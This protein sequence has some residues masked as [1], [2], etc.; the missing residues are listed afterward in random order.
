[1]HIMSVLFRKKP[2][3]TISMTQKKETNALSTAKKNNTNAVSNSDKNNTNAVRMTPKNDTSAVSISQK[4]NTSDVSISQKNDTSA[5]SISQ[6]NNMS[7]VSI[8]HKEDLKSP[9]SITLKKDTTCAVGIVPKTDTN[10]DARITPKQEMENTGSV[11]RRQVTKSDLCST[12][13]QDRNSNASV[14]R[15]EIRST[16]STQVHITNK[17]FDS[18]VDRRADSG[19]KKGLLSKILLA[20][21]KAN[22]QRLDG[23]NQPIPLDS[24]HFKENYSL[25]G[26]R[27]KMG[28]EE[29]HRSHYQTSG[30]GPPNFPSRR[31]NVYDHRV[32]VCERWKSEEEAS[33]SS[34]RYFDHSSTRTFSRWRSEDDVSYP[35]QLEED[36][37]YPSQCEDHISYPSHC[38]DDVSYPSQ[39]EDDVSY[40]S[41]R[42]DD[43][44]YPSQREDDVSYPSQREDDVSYQ[45]CKDDVS[46]S[47]QHEDDVSYPSQRKDNVSYPS[48]HEDD[49]SYP[50]QR[51]DDVSYPS[52]CEDTRNHPWTYSQ[53]QR[54]EIFTFSARGHYRS[55]KSYDD[56]NYLYRD[57]Y[58]D[59]E[60]DPEY[61]HGREYDPKY[62]R[63]Y[64]R[65][66]YPD[67]EYDPDYDPSRR[68]YSRWEDNR[69]HVHPVTK[70]T[71]YRRQ[72]NIETTPRTV[73]YRHLARVTQRKRFSAFRCHSRLVSRMSDTRKTDI[74]DKQASPCDMS[75]HLKVKLTNPSELTTIESELEMAGKRDDKDS[76]KTKS[77]QKAKRHVTVPGDQMGDGDESQTGES[78]ALVLTE[79]DPLVDEETS[80]KPEHIADLHPSTCSKSQ[81]STTEQMLEH[82]VPE[83]LEKSVGLVTAMQC[84]QVDETNKMDTSSFQSVRSALPEC[85]KSL[86]EHESLDNDHL[87]GFIIPVHVGKCPARTSEKTY[88]CTKNISKNVPLNSRNIIKLTTDSDKKMTLSV[89]RTVSDCDIQSHLQ[90]VSEHDIQFHLQSVS[91]HD[92][93]SH[94]QSISDHDIQSHLQSVS[95]HD[96]QSHLQSDSDHDIQSHLQ[97]DSDH[98]IQ[99]HLQSVSDHDI[100]SHLQSVSDHDIQ[101]HFQSDSDHDIQS[102][103]QSVSDHDIQSHL[104]S[105]SDHD[106]QSHLQSDSDHDIQFH[107][108]TENTNNSALEDLEITMCSKT[109][110]TESIPSGNLTSF[111]VFDGSEDFIPEG[112]T[113]QKSDAHKSSSED[114]SIRKG[115]ESV[116][117]TTIP[118]SA[119]V[120]SERSV[121]DAVNRYVD[122]VPKNSRPCESHQV[123]NIPLP[124][125]F[126]DVTDHHEREGSTDA[127]IK[128]DVKESQDMVSKTIESDSPQSPAADIEMD[129]QKNDDALNVDLHADGQLLLGTEKMSSVGEIPLLHTQCSDAQPSGVAFRKGKNDLQVTF[130]SRQDNIDFSEISLPQRFK[131][132]DI[133][134]QH[135]EHVPKIHTVFK[136]NDVRSSRTIIPAASQVLTKQ[137]GPLALSVSQ[138]TEIKTEGSSTTETGDQNGKVDLVFSPIRPVVTSPQ[139]GQ[140]PGSKCR[141]ESQQKVA[142][143][144]DVP[145]IPTFAVSVELVH[146][147]SVG[148][149][150]SPDKKSDKNVTKDDKSADD[151]CPVK[152]ADGPAKDTKG[153]GNKTVLLA[154]VLS[155]AR[156][157]DILISK[158]SKQIKAKENEVHNSETLPESNTSSD[159]THLCSDDKQMKE[160]KQNDSHSHEGALFSPLV[161]NSPCLGSKNTD[162]WLP[163]SYMEHNIPN[164]TFKS[165]P[166]PQ[167]SVTSEQNIPKPVQSLSTQLSTP[168]IPCVS[169]SAQSFPSQSSVQKIPCI[170]SNTVEPVAPY[171]QV[172]K[173]SSGQNIPSVSPTSTEVLTSSPKRARHSSGKASV[174]T[175]GICTSNL[176]EVPLVQL[177]TL[178]GSLCRS[179]SIS[180][181]SYNPPIHM[182]GIIPEDLPKCAT[183]KSVGLLTNQSPVSVQDINDDGE[184]ARIDETSSISSKEKT[185]TKNVVFLQNDS[186]NVLKKHI[187][188]DFSLQAST[189]YV[190]LVGDN[191]KGID[192]QKNDL[193]LER[194]QEH[195]AETWTSDGHS[196]KRRFC[197]DDNVVPV[198]QHSA[199]VTAAR[200]IMTHGRSTSSK[201]GLS[202]TRYSLDTDSTKQRQSSS[203]H[204]NT[205][206][207]TWSEMDKNGT[208][209]SFNKSQMSSFKKIFQESTRNKPVRTTYASIACP[210]SDLHVPIQTSASMAKHSSENKKSHPAAPSVFLGIT[211]YSVKPHKVKPYKS[212]HSW[213]DEKSHSSKSFVL[214]KR[215][216]LDSAWDPDA[217]E[218]LTDVAGK[219]HKVEKRQNPSVVQKRKVIIPKTLTHSECI[220]VESSA[221]SKRVSSQYEVKHSASSSQVKDS[222]EQSSELRFKSKHSAVL[223]GSKG[224]EGGLESK[225]STVHSRSSVVPPSVSSTET[226]AVHSGS[227]MSD[228]ELEL[229]HSTVHSRSSV[230][231]PSVSSTETLAVHSGSKMSD[232]ELE[233]K[234][235]TV[236]SR[237]SVVPPSV[238]STETLAV[239]SGS[240]MSDLELEPKHSI[241]YSGSKSLD[242]ELESKHFGVHS[243][244][245][246]SALK[247]ELKHCVVQ[248][249]PKTLDPLLEAKYSGILSGAKSSEVKLKPAESTKKSSETETVLKSSETQ[250]KLKH[251]PVPSSSKSGDVELKPNCSEDFTTS[252]TAAVIGSEDEKSAA[253]VFS[254]NDTSVTATTTISRTNK[255]VSSK[256]VTHFHGEDGDL[257]SIDVESDDDSVDEL[258]NETP[259]ILQSL[260][261]RCNRASPATPDCTL[262]SSQLSDD[263][264]LDLQIATSP[265]HISKPA[266]TSKSGFSLDFLL[267]EKIEKEEENRELDI[268]HAE[269]KEGIKK[270]GFAKLTFDSEDGN[271]GDLLPEYQ[272][273][274]HHF[275][276]SKSVIEDV[277]PGDQVFSA[278][279]FQQ[280][281][282]ERILP[283]SCG[284]VSSNTTIDKHLFTIEPALVCDLVN[285]N[286][287]SLCFHAIASKDA[288]LRWLFFLLSIHSSSVLLHGCKKVLFDILHT[289][290]CSDKTTT[291]TPDILDILRVF[292]NYGAKAEDLML[293]QT[294]FTEE[295]IRKAFEAPSDGNVQQNIPNVNAYQ[296]LN[297]ENI[298][299]VIQTIS[300]ALQGRPKY[301]TEELN[302][303]LVMVLKVALDTALNNSALDYD[304]QVCVASIL[305]NYGKEE[306]PE[307]I[308]DLCLVLSGITKHHHNKV[309]MAQLLPN[310]KRGRYVQR[311][312]SYV[313]LRQLLF[314]SNCLTH[315]S[316]LVNLQVRTLSGLFHHICDL[317]SED[318]YALASAITLL[319]M[320]VGNECLKSSEKVDLDYLTGQL[321]FLMSDVRDNVRMLDKTRVKDMMVR[322]SSKWTLMMHAMGSKQKS[323]FAWAKE[324]NP[325]TMTV[326]RLETGLSDQETE[327][328]DQTDDDDDDDV[329]VESPQQTETIHSDVHGATC[330]DETS[331]RNLAE[332]EPD[333]VVETESEAV[334]ETEPD[335]VVNVFLQNESDT[336]ED[337]IIML[338]D[339]SNEE[340]DDLPD[341]NM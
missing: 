198:I 42:E 217:P 148:K 238:S 6:K 16:V 204:S 144:P 36:V 2:Q 124:H 117:K 86:D 210:Q 328:S 227:K 182:T 270:G 327:V 24:I 60:Y 215:Y 39:H 232:L 76:T 37:S 170:V 206:H 172:S 255:T 235:S 245:G 131:E 275:K 251:S 280:L 20:N 158:Y 68:E 287:L 180:S 94:L 70:G 298:S 340:D 319:D 250:T 303:L 143:S 219:V 278:D 323:L 263:D 308:P 89:E 302:C 237:S 34:S 246:S 305:E 312:L 43:V 271:E 315:H 47:S 236:H 171:L 79:M 167:L 72:Q 164:T 218:P 100:Q 242:F 65:G 341:P 153:S 18:K 3:S 187:A 282:T 145:S 274:L 147:N 127:T 135:K 231:P 33:H 277:H 259:A 101:S 281:F 335:T 333:T 66:R 240:K 252:E 15:N 301:K 313:F 95:D 121:S 272:Q 78:I 321:K 178:S 96:I 185:P 192:K 12:Q 289:Q 197:S 67:Y 264:S 122:S 207:L 265:V 93:P 291:W 214:P 125:E 203:H 155:V 40:P 32:P 61:A 269:L 27:S 25:N 123:Q 213:S 55:Y 234:H 149:T 138:D 186:E 5:V 325:Q 201:E 184:C 228:L 258:L 176:K 114:T 166:V 224:S 154:S 115:P 102:H 189:K 179:P 26:N 69:T 134:K 212:V 318:L 267:A 1:M 139:T 150:P 119:S 292:V 59:K 23:E 229:K 30:C 83:K 248:L 221:E 316:E 91:D 195:K 126:H 273:K 244:S 300:Y 256:Y 216:S 161:Q 165:A 90:S 320:S 142:V 230:V 77:D 49:V 226:L 283:P 193:N 331:G 202:S 98:D 288:M 140:V 168:K 87:K 223:V 177:S 304:L 21:Q 220:A 225:H 133:K 48:Q 209:S 73:F 136:S 294:A 52:Q 108:Q 183:A 106:I 268:M 266:G 233:L 38:E 334:L 118:P 88:S 332:T 29:F 159:E 85:E 169:Q 243:G 103:H 339:D 64:D 45:Q 330:V 62:Y 137:A 75:E 286:T 105:V 54:R 162:P 74:S 50:S 314:P 295:Q 194:I 10:S 200:R 156:D 111:N 92:I 104:Q 249:G 196:R 174:P 22:K 110:N 17:T 8:T 279:H 58:Q 297:Q 188:P 120:K 306:W 260:E 247:L 276:V 28:F 290:H 116:S 160:P 157:I 129:T 53:S 46:Y 285:T 199:A 113:T 310:G 35:S 309:H 146:T 51:E 71:R 112:N 63:E 293:G 261:Q 99:S 56:K 326:E 128:S 151:V 307:M 81:V 82:K 181:Q 222:S 324:R 7:D 241:V 44:S 11:T 311:R 190:S 173:S 57:Y 253:L 41:Q 208:C 296:R 31:G 130:K 9:A 239:H 329:D 132:L 336:D 338:S 152:L 97:S 317:A 262:E 254:G 19:R 257:S 299:M 175:S 14:R 13:K 84:L 337:D 141:N 163:K 4:N 109:K 205:S 107:L 211:S 80:T 284:F 322:V 191:V